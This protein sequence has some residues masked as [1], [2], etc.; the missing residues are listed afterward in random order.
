MARPVPAGS[1][2]LT[3]EALAEA[4][5]LPYDDELDVRVVRAEYL[6]AEATKLG[7]PKDIQRIVSLLELDEFD[8]DHLREIIEKHSLAERW[9]RVQNIIDPE[10]GG[11]K[12]RL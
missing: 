5:Y 3:S 4:Q 11:P 9:N 10:S 7:R 8:H 1:D 12:I 6:A 2:S